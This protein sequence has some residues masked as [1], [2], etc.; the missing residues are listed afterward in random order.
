MDA[1][2][3]VVL[4]K[5]NVER[6]VTVTRFNVDRQ[7]YVTAANQSLQ[8]GKKGERGTRITN[9]ANILV[10]DY[11]Y[12][13]SWKGHF[14]GRVHTGSGKVEY[15][16]VPSLVDRRSGNEARVWGKAPLNDTRN[17]R[18]VDIGAVDKRSKGDGW[19]HV[20]AAS[21][22]V[23]GSRIYFPTM[24]GVVYV[25]DS[26]AKIW[27]EKALLAI[28]DMGPATQTW[29]LASLSV[30]HGRIYHRTMK[31]VVCIGKPFGEGGGR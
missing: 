21:P 6:D 3:G 8:V 20:S 4:R 10:G 17:S 7:E 23:V 24:L 1:V 12:F 15:L 13:L 25:L 30:A 22:I 11:H 2:K 19:G 9:Q 14:I 26:A 29:S 31:G 16:E 5:D 18:G 28:N 27:D